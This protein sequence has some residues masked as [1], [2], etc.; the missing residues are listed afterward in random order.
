[1]LP[2]LTSLCRQTVQVAA[3]T[4]VDGYGQPTYGSNVAYRVRISGK[5]RLIRNDQG[6]EVLSTHSVYFAASPA[7][8]AHDKITLS[9]GDVNSTETGAINP[10]ILSVGKFPD[11]QGRTNLT[12]FLA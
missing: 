12:V 5:R 8:G 2:E 11:D 6:A 7:V 3:R 4:G 9:T 10:A 1:M